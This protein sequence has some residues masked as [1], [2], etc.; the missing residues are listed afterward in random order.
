M[1]PMALHLEMTV[2]ITGPPGSSYIC[3]C[4][5]FFK[6]LRQMPSLGHTYGYPRGSRIISWEAFYHFENELARTTWWRALDIICCRRREN[7]MPGIWFSISEK[8]IDEKKN[9]ITSHE[10]KAQLKEVKIKVERKGRRRK[11]E[12][13]VIWRRTIGLWLPLHRSTRLSFWERNKWKQI[14]MSNWTE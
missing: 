2:L 1:G 11:K 6:I 10:L 5:F 8:K 4:V 9:E 14:P 7:L 13:C 12:A 3:S